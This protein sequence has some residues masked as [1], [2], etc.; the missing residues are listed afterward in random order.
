MT[1]RPNPD[2]N[3]MKIEFGMYAQV[4]EDNDPTNTN[5]SWTTGAIAL[6]PTGNEQGD[7]YFMSL[8]TG[9][10][11]SRKKWTALPMP[12]KVIKA[13]EA[14]AEAEGQPLIMGGCPL[15]EWAPKNQAVVENENEPTGDE[16]ANVKQDLNDGSANEVNFRD[17]YPHM[18]DPANDEG[19]GHDIDE[20]EVPNE[21]NDNVDV[22]DDD[23]PTDDDDEPAVGKNQGV[24]EIDDEVAE[25][26]D[27]EVHEAPGVED[28]GADEVGQTHGYNLRGTRDRDFSH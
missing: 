19:L 10:Q 12:N 20:P 2:Y 8:S 24:P 25:V 21:D 23:A 27:T 16:D 26:P 15:F 3:S 17:K 5:T 18:D 28:Q 1:G 4:F 22:Q 11:L 7:Y 13:V 9:K 6:N 14:R